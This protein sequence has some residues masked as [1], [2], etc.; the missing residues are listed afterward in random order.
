MWV[1]TAEEK[2][3]G[4]LAGD[5]SAIDG[6]VG[7]SSVY[8]FSYAA[9]VTPASGQYYFEGVL[10]HEFSE[11]LGRELM[12]GEGLGG[13][14]SYTPMDPFRYSGPGAR[15]LGTGGPAYFSTTAAPRTWIPGTPTPR[16]SRGLGQQRR[17]RFFPGVQPV[18]PA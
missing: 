8:P 4:L 17:S 5:N 13:T 2:A 7:L 12:L 15:Q 11:V 1:S 9:G 18:R 14:T 16:R 3:L 6:Y 10:A